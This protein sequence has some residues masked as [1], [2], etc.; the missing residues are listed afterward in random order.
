MDSTGDT[1]LPRIIFAEDN[2][3]HAFL[4]RR[5]LERHCVLT[6]ASDGE[7]LLEILESWMDELPR[8]MLI[9]VNLPRLSGLEVLEKLRAKPE[10]RCVP[11]V[12]FSTSKLRLEVERALSAG[13]NSFVVKPAKFTEFRAV[14]EK[15]VE[16][17]TKVNASPS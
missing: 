4:I 13:A 3:D 14:L 2:P 12:V 17:W 8:L 10:W 15:I 5:V 11:M 6:Y 1:V 16:Y 7:Q 9:D